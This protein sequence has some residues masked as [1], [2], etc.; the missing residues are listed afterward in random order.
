[1]QSCRDTNTS[2]AGWWYSLILYRDYNIIILFIQ[3]ISLCSSLTFLQA[4]ITSYLT[5]CTVHMYTHAQRCCSVFLQGHYYPQMLS[6]TKPLYVHMYFTVHPTVPSS[7]R[8]LTV[9][10]EF[11]D[12]SELNWLPPTKPNGEVLHYVIHYTPEGGTEQNSSTG[13]NLTHYNLTGL[14]RNRVY[15]N[16]SVQAVN[17][18]GRSVRSAVIAQ[19]NH[20]PPI[21]KLLWMHQALTS[22]QNAH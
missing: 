21:G 18:A 10:R 13:S 11:E 7:P 19:Y 6:I 4:I 22:L 15:T 14:E 12:G 20:T 2:T 1:M 16:I 5:L 17:S 3:Q 9:T 8:Q